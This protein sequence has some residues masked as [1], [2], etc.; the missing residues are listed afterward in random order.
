MQALS[1]TVGM[2]NYDMQIIERE[3]QQIVT[4]LQVVAAKTTPIRDELV[5]FLKRDI[6]PLEPG[7]DTED[8]VRSVGEDTYDAMNELDDFISGYLENVES[9][10]NQT[11]QFTG[12]IENILDQLV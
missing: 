12:R 2:V 1:D 9:G 11:S 5:D 10:I 8:M 4:T 3:V 6:C 7:S